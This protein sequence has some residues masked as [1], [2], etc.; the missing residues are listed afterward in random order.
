MS[1][2]F[3]A[4]HIN[5]FTHSGDKIRTKVFDFRNQKDTTYYL[6]IRSSK[7]KKEAS[8]FD[9]KK[10]LF[11]R[12]EIDSEFSKV[13]DLRLLKNAILF[14]YPETY[15]P[16]KVKNV[17][18][19]VE[20]E[21]DTVNHQTIVH[22]VN[23]KNNKRKKIINEHYYFFGK[24]GKPYSLSKKTLKDY[25]AEKENIKIDDDENLEKVMHLSN[26]KINYITENFEYTPIDIQFEFLINKTFP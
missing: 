14:K 24:K 2:Y 11:I 9:S 18:T 23:Y 6:Q 12:F 26:G 21:K 1:Y 15:K 16:K 20:A 19:K 3:N 22:I 10:D 5:D 17:V 25:L 8:L 13:D 4:I 7:E